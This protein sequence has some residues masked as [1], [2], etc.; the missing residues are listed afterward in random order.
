LEVN[1]HFKNISLLIFRVEAK[2]RQEAIMKHAGRK[3]FRN[4]ARLEFYRNWA[5]PE[6]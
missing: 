2:T 4:I 6:F 3:E 5:I 1:G